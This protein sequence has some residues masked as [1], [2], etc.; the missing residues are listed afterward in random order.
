MTLKSHAIQ[1]N[2]SEC[3]AAMAKWLGSVPVWCCQQKNACQKNRVI[4]M[5]DG[6]KAVLGSESSNGC[7][8]WVRS[9]S[10]FEIGGLN[11][12]M[13]QLQ[14]EAD[15]GPA[16]TMEHHCVGPDDSALAF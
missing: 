15:I 1:W 8:D 6:F 7:R 11:A 3:E 4:P 13:Q 12:F 10:V 14:M 5:F 9:R 16:E 2:W